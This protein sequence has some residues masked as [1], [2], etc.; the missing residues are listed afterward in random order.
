MNFALR[1]SGEGSTLADY[2]LI[3][4]ERSILVTYLLAMVRTNQTMEEEDKQLKNVYK[5]ALVEEG[6]DDGDIDKRY[7][8][9]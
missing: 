7:R 5:C 1:L 3:T 4:E 8:Q 2:P 6:G 9:Q